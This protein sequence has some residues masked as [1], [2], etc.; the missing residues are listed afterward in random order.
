MKKV[1][2]FLLLILIPF[3]VL[4]SDTM[5]VISE[6]ESTIK[7][8]ENSSLAQNATSAILIEATTGEIL[9]EKN[10]HEKLAPASMTKIMSML[11]IV[12]SIE[13]G[14]INWDDVITVS[15][16]AS[17]MGGSQILLETGEQMKVSDL[18]KGIAVASGNDAVV[19][20][21]E[22]IAG[23][24]DEFVNMMNQKAKELGLKNTN[25]KNPHGLDEANHYSS[26]YDMSIMAKELI[27]HEKVLEFTSIY[28]DYLR[29]GTD[30]EFWLVNTNKLVRFYDGVD[31]LKTGYTKTA[32]YCLVA[33]AKKNNMR[34]L[35]IVLDEP[36][37]ELRNKEVSEML[38]YAYAQYELGTAINTDKVL[39]KAKVEKGYKDEVEIVPS[40][41]V[42]FL[43]NKMDEDPKIDLTI[44]VNNIKAPIKKG[45]KV[46][47]MKVRINNFY[48]VV[49]LTV[50]ED[51][52]KITFF[53]LLTRKFKLIFN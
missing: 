6:L 39:K 35:A 42:T 43:K 49:E 15:E 44:D 7:E 8:T 24:V 52:N 14:V 9:F 3:N 37:S 31:G 51:I 27:K 18:F 22:T 21:A 25:F 19:A 46:G 13:K 2:I 29:K 45:D 20:L 50:N 10:A 28:E 36:S 4:A 1:I 23:T 30:R 33:T 41:K 48:E 32:G 47:T 26:A 34:I 11:I 12:E 5:P 38:D 17:S 53:Q 40:K 16:N